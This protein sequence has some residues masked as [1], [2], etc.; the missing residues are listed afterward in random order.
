MSQ[1]TEAQNLQVA[2]KTSV[3]EL[4]KQENITYNL[5]QV[6]KN[7]FSYVSANSVSFSAEDLELLEGQ[8][9]EIVDSTKLE[10]T[11]HID[12][13]IQ[14]AKGEYIFDE[15]KT[16]YVWQGAEYELWE[17]NEDEKK[18]LFFQ[19]ANGEPIFYSSN[20][21]LVIHWDN[22]YKVTHY[23]QRLLEEFIN[24][25]RKK[26][27]ITQDE[28]IGSLATRGYLKH[29][30]EIIGVTLGYSTLVQLT[31]TQVFAPTWNIRVKLE[32]GEIEDYFI[33]AIEGKVIDFQM[34]RGQEE[35]TD[36]VEE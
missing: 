15:F 32:D 31:E 35:E 16:K 17:V 8:D 18:A 3:E 9:I 29:G 4:L 26:D 1:H 20:A 5:P 22:D 23:E 6:V 34:D 25:N 33:N 30:S 14:N 7:N 19:K 2:G 11:F 27:L 21:M 24:F 36:E 28:V 10:S 12:V 13:P